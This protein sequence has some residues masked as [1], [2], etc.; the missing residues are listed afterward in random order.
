MILMRTDTGK[1]LVEVIGQLLRECNRL[2]GLGPQ[3]TEQERD[4]FARRKGEVL[5][6]IVIEHAQNAGTAAVERQPGDASPYVGFDDRG[7]ER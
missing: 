5:E 4:A 6:G 1:A 2:V 7:S 3:A